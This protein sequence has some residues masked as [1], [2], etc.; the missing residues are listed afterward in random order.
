[1]LLSCRR[2]CDFLLEYLLC[3]VTERDFFHL[4]F[5]C[6]ILACAQREEGV[7]WALCA[8]M[9]LRAACSS[10]SFAMFAVSALSQH[11]MFA[12]TLT[13][14]LHP[15]LV[16]LRPFIAS[17]TLCCQPLDRASSS[18]CLRCFLLST[19]PKAQEHSSDL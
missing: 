17:R 13:F 6:F 16:I 11:L 9:D 18:E 7:C 3:C 8:Y 12:Q 19:R 14:Q 4:C 2:Q 10:L 5:V 15:P 1:M